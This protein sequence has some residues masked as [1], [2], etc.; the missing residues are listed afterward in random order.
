[1][2]ENSLFDSI[3]AFSAL[4]DASSRATKGK[5]SKRDVAEL[6]A[7]QEHEILALECELRS[8]A[9][10]LGRCRRVEV[11]DPKRRIVSAALFRDRFVHHALHAVLGGIFER[12]FIFDSYANRKGKG[13]H[14]AVARYEKFR[15]RF[16]YVLRY[17]IYRYFSAIDHEILK[18]D[19]RRRITCLR[20]LNL[21][22]RIFDASNPQEP[23][24]IHLLGDEVFTPLELI[25]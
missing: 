17:D 9:C 1:M 14:R 20:T 12:G 11:F 5:R 24:N 19:I 6:L 3:A 15:D 23:V 13:T 22:D 2:K 10:Q 18:Q 8:E 25:Q 7:N 16:C 21:V 4:L